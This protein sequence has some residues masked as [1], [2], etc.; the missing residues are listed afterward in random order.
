[1]D[2]P[3]KIF[4]GAGIDQK[5]KSRFGYAWVQDAQNPS[6]PKAYVISGKDVKLADAQF[7]AATRALKSLSFQQKF[8]AKSMPFM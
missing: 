6:D 2:F 1:M 8:L 4:I 3:V 5:A 7:I